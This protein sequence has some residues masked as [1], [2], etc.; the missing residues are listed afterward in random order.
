M[1]R[2]QYTTH[3]VRVTARHKQ[4]LPMVSAYCTRLNAALRKALSCR[5]V[6][7]SR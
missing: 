3:A 2:D 6:G 7:A 1:P 5:A 4:R